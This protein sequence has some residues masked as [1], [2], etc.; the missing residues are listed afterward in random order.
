MFHVC[1]VSHGELFTINIIDVDIAHGA[2]TV[3][4][5]MHVACSIVENK[6]STD[7]ASI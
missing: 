3:E 7:H 2:L 5:E 6:V 1:E 4:T